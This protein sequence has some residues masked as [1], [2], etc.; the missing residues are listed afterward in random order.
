MIDSDY[1]RLKAYSGSG[2]FAGFV[3]RIADRLL[4]DF[5]R[6]S[7]G[8]RRGV[9]VPLDHHLD[10]VDDMEPTPDENFIRLEDD[11]HLAAALDVLTRA[12]PTLQEDERL[13]LGIALSAVQT[14]PSREIAR[15]MQ[16]PVADIY[17]LKQRV[18]NRLWSRS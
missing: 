9:P 3:L 15:L 18:L 6:S 2:S 4:I 12:I 11:E 5:L 14:P 8:R 16:R 7:F 13:Y 1:C 10:I 17:K